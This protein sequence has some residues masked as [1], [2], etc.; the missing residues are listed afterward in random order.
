VPSPHILILYYSR[1]GG[2][3]NLALHIARGVDK[4]GG[5]QARIRTV[6]EVATTTERTAPPVPDEGA[7]YCTK[8]DLA[9]CAGLA[10]GSA[11]R[12][13][14]MSAPLKYF[15]DT[16]ADLWMGRNLVGKPASVFTSSNSLHGGQET[17]LLTMMVPLMHHG[18]IIQ[19]LPYA[20]PALNATTTGGT[21]YGVT[22]VGAHGPELSE[23]EA[24][25]AVAQGQ[26]LAQLAQRLA[27]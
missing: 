15:L 8:E 10:L 18:M 25:L 16:T 3:K 19:S 2:T 24:Q 22:H 20:E 13:G 12:F 11:T 9:E 7:I 5:I 14:N 26:R 6:P 23:H 4:V 21:P 17:T 1:T 27:D